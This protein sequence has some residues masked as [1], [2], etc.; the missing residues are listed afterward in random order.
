MSIESIP[1]TIIVDIDGTLI[2]HHGSLSAQITNEPELLPNV[3]KKFS[4]W[5][6]A[7]CKII[8]LSGRRESMR[9][10]T[11]DQLISLG[12]FWDQLILGATRGKRILIND[13]KTNSI[14]HTA[15][16]VN[17]ERNKGFN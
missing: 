7:G 10:A 2:K 14:E 12:L 1:S 11:E 17:L 15:E 4:D 9:K 5:D 6:K 8:L 13:M 3:L 16:A